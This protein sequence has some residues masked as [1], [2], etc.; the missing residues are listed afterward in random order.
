MKKPLF[1]KQ[2]DGWMDDETIARKLQVK[3]M[4]VMRPDRPFALL[5]ILFGGRNLF[6]ELY[7]N[8]IYMQI[9]NSKYIC[10]KKIKKKIE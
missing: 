4:R 1:L 5:V 10:L 9:V 6:S 7:V 8:Q 3:R 2:M